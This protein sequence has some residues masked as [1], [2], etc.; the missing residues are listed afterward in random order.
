MRLA[1]AHVTS[2]TRTLETGQPSTMNR[3][4][5]RVALALA[6]SAGAGELAES[7]HAESGTL[8][9]NGSTRPISVPLPIGTAPA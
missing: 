6:A 9:K 5:D 7:A 3:P 1:C 8:T 4:H 2:V